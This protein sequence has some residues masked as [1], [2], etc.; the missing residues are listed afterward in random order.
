[1]TWTEVGTLDDRDD[2]GGI[3]VG[4]A[5]GRRFADTQRRDDRFADLTGLQAAVDVHYYVARDDE[6]TRGAQPGYWVC[7]STTYTV[8]TDARRP[9][10]TEQ[11]SDAMSNDD[12]RDRHTFGQEW[13]AEDRAR[14]L[15]TAYRPSAL[16]WDGRAF[17]SWSDAP[18][19]K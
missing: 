5:F 10:D 13:Q 14:Q 18:H 4:K 7:R 8:C 12:D 6:C 11:W 3:Q 1:M 15:A 19:P 17:H 2:L 9:G 16:T